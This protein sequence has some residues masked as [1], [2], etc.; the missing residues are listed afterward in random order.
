[1]C[2]VQ[3]LQAQLADIE[4]DN[5]SSS[6]RSSV[7]EPARPQL[8]SMPVEIFL[9]ICSFLDADFLSHTL[10]KVC[11]RFQTI[12]EDSHIWKYWYHSKLEGS[13]YPPLPHL[14]YWE[15]EPIDWQSMCVESASEKR[16]WE[17]VR[18]TMKHIVV[19]DIHFASVDTVL[20]VNNGEFCISGG[21]D[22]G[23]ALWC[24]ADISPAGPEVATP[25]RAPGGGVSH[26]VLATTQPRH[27]RHGAHEG[28]VW[29]LAADCEHNTKFVYSASWDNSV[30][31]WDLNRDFTPV[32]SYRCGMSALCVDTCGDMVLAGLYSKRIM[33]FDVR[34]GTEAVCKYKPHRGPVLG[35]A[36]L[37]PQVASVSEDRTLAV[38]D[39][40]ARRTLVQDLRLPTE[41]AYPVC[42]SWARPALYVG[43]SK[44]G[45]HLL[46]PEKFSLVATHEVWQEPPSTQPAS[47]ITGCLQTAAGLILVSDRGEVKFLY[48]SFP[49]REYCSTRTTAPDV[50]QVRYL[51]G[52]LVVGSCDSALEFWIPA[53][54]YDSAIPTRDSSS[55]SGIPTR[56]SSSDSAIPTEGSS[57]ES[58]E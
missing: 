45:L 51:N 16:R 55:Y 17:N 27:I 18:E 4:H 30:K 28:W 9:K 40:R 1:M 33:A 21:R 25:S 8:L 42:V 49:P 41:K 5:E 14:Q 10:A 52:I 26:A 57:T 6:E 29:D 31:V 38:W 7:Y 36:T 35:L 50:T 56:D 2:E 3:S 11:T 48:N 58:P 23:M 15:E 39:A 19:K 47:K 37:G 32:H 22:R 13:V 34:V 53:E 43:D 54:R 44:G 20:L 46:H 24:V 12:L